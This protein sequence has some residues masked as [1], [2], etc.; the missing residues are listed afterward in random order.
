MLQIGEDI[1]IKKPTLEK[2]ELYL[3]DRIEREEADP[4]NS[5][6][7][8]E[9]FARMYLNMITVRWRISLCQIQCAIRFIDRYF[10]IAIV[11]KSAQRRSLRLAIGYLD[12][13]CK[14]EFRAEQSAIYGFL[15]R[16]PTLTEDERVSAVEA[17]QREA[18]AQ[19]AIQE[20]LMEERRDDELDRLMAEFEQECKLIDEAFEKQAQSHDD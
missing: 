4:Q 8:N 7:M 6:N 15:E 14:P 19:E 13:S 18:M 12:K 16:D 10:D 1:G 17:E 2:L 9:N 20:I 3:L 11:P 5:F